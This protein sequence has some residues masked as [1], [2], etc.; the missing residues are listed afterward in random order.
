MT[1]KEDLRQLLDAG[2]GERVEFK[3][4]LRWNRRRKQL[5][6][7]LQSIV[8]KTLAGFLNG[9]GGTLLI[10]ISDA[11]TA[12]G[13]A[14]D[15]K[16]LPPKR[17]NRDGF[18]LHFWNLI[19]GQIGGAATAYLEVTFHE[20]DGEDICQITVEPSNDPVYAKE[21]Q[22]QETL[23]LRTGNSTRA[24]PISEAVKYVRTR[25]GTTEPNGT[26]D[27]RT[28]VPLESWEIPGARTQKFKLYEA[29]CY[30]ARAN[31]AWPLPTEAREEY[32]Q[33]LKTI[34]KE[35]LDKKDQP[36]HDTLSFKA[37]FLTGDGERRPDKRYTLE[38][39]RQVLRR[40]LLS[41]NRS[42]PAF[43]EERFDEWN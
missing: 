38:I 32:D 24:L 36:G 7:N 6:K 29:A 40:Y 4:S 30:L 2:E 5:D 34:E 1:A 3:A 14:D 21:S 13:I 19:V 23:Y 25:W 22:N 37:G 8:V 20:V 15:I 41:L 28:S 33:L 12:V 16:T 43:L 35:G 18:E 17:Q 39:E 42:I 10:G 27:E 31:P 11:G 9:V 26:L